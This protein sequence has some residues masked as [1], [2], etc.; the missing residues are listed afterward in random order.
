MGCYFHYINSLIREARIKHIT[1]KDLNDITKIILIKLSKIPFKYLNDKEYSKKCIITLVKFIRN[2]K[3]YK[4]SKDL[5]YIY[6]LYW[7]KEWFN[8]FSY[9]LLNYRGIPAII[10]TNKFLES[11]NKI[12]KNALKEEYKKNLKNFPI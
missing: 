12:V 3:I 6:L 9:G 1:N 4:S 5:Y 10:R 2:S 11:Y 8:Y 7:V